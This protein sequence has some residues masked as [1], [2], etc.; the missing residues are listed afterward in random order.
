MEG[1]YTIILLVDGENYALVS[2][3]REDFSDK[4][5][6]PSVPPHITLREDFFSDNIDVFIE[7]YKQKIKDIS[8]FELEFSGVDVFQRGHIVFKV[9][10]NSVLQHLHELTVETSQKFVSTPRV[11]N[12]ECDLN[13]EQKVLVEKYQLPFYFKYYTPHMTVVQLTD[14]SVK[15]DVLCE[16]RKKGL[17]S[18]F[19]VKEVC[20]YDKLESDVYTFIKL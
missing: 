14:F 17:P 6:I 16:I 13:E 3:F 19:V 15:E 18:V 8:P 2:K 4:L 7:E 9:K 10:N 12:F 11:R 1:R 20:I 5:K